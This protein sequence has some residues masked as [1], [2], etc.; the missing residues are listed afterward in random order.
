MVNL[1][2]YFPPKIHVIVYDVYL[3]RH[4]QENEKPRHRLHL[5]QKIVNILRSKSSPVVQ[6]GIGMGVCHVCGFV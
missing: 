4:F 3:Y 2:S 6:V 1:C 5:H